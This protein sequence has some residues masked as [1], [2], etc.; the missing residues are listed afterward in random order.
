MLLY[1]DPLH[2]MKEPWL[3]ENNKTCSDSQNSRVGRSAPA[4][5][6]LVF[7]RVSPDRVKE[8]SRVFKE[9]VKCVSRKF[10]KKFQGSFKNLSMKVCFAILL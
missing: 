6:G 10:Q 8:V 9:I 1:S 7:Q 4:R 3:K 5:P 2:P